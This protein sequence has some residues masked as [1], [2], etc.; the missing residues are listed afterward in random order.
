MHLKA[1]AAA[2]LILATT[3][4]SH[5][6][7][8][9]TDWLTAGD[10]AATYDTTTGLTWLKL[11]NTFQVSYATVISELSTT[12]SGWRV[13]TEDEVLELMAQ[14]E[15]LSPY[16]LGGY[17]T[18]TDE[19][20]QSFNDALGTTSASD[21]TLG[22][23]LINGS[24]T[25]SGVRNQSSLYDYI[26]M[27]RSASSGALYSIFLVSDESF[28]DITIDA[29]TPFAIASLSLLLMGFRRNNSNVCATRT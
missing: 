1:L 20:R 3:T 23:A 2:A 27:L 18:A 24:Y 5:A 9:D 14:F 22:L 17:T 12:Y 13:P 21:L 29:N 7:F 8:I 26:Y 15:T 16:N 19:V 4:S 10:N 11:E 6:E 25:I 28:S